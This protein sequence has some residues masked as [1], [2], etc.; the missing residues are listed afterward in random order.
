MCLKQGLAPSCHPYF[1]WDQGSFR[2]MN[3][4]NATVLYDYMCLYVL[5]NYADIY[6]VCMSTMVYIYTHTRIYVYMNSFMPAHREFVRK[7][8]FHM[9]ESSVLAVCLGPYIGNQSQTD[10]V[11]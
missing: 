5:Y 1:W 7:T 9:V 6:K 2:L 8:W 10:I 4:Y 3:V 11:H